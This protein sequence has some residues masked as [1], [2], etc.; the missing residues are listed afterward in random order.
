VIT[1]G[2]VALVLAFPLAA[3]CAFRHDAGISAIVAHLQ[4]LREQVETW[5]AAHDH[6]VTSLCRR[7]TDV[8]AAAARAEEEARIVSVQL[9]E[10]CEG[11]SHVRQR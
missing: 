3:Y 9:T 7:M 8:E 4:A 10:L 1:L 11:L 6:Q 2:L 5:Q